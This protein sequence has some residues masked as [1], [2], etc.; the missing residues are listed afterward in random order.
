M[1]KKLIG[2]TILAGALALSATVAQASEL[3]DADILA[4]ADSKRGSTHGATWTLG[5]ET[6]SDASTLTVTARD[7]DFLAEYTAPDSQAGE[8]ILERGQ[9]MWFIKPG[10]SNPI[11]ISPRQKLLG[12]A[13]YGDIASQRWTTDYSVQ[14][15]YESVVDGESVY[16]FDLQGN[17]HATYD[18]ITLYIDMDDLYAVRSEMM[19]ADGDLLKTA[20]YEYDNEVGGRYAAADDQPDDSEF[21]SSMT[22]VSAD[23]SDTTTLTYSDVSFSHVSADSFSL[24]NVME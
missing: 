9:N 11:P 22:I 4:A 19:T 13:S 7:D 12:A 1:I 6:S 24:S 20:T 16:V 17:E 3:S 21:I 5:V 18:A 23:G 15:R 2:T 14:R 8:M 10:T